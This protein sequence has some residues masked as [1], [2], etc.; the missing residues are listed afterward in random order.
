MLGLFLLSL[1]GA[2]SGPRLSLRRSRGDCSPAQVS[3]TTCEC[4][5]R[6]RALGVHVQPRP[7]VS[8]CVYPGCAEE[9]E[10][11]SPGGRRDQR[12]LLPAPPPGPGINRIAP[13]RPSLP[14]NTPPPTL[15]FTLSAGLGEWSVRRAP[16]S[17]RTVWS[18]AILGVAGGCPCSA[19]RCRGSAGRSS[20][21]MRTVH[22]RSRAS[23]IGEEEG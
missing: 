20:G 8:V 7:C 13:S 3:V 12:S 15:F 17:L 6:Q 2:P 18:L 21:R 23:E 4:R 14:P 9:E 5:R 11:G 19:Q 22:R 16:R 10:P 1:L